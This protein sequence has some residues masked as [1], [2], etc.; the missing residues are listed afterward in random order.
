MFHAR[1]GRLSTT[2]E[3]TRRS[4]VA[5]TSR[6]NC[7]F[8]VHTLYQRRDVGATFCSCQTS[9]LICLI[10]ERVKFLSVCACLQSVHTVKRQQNSL[11]NISSSQCSTIEIPRTCSFLHTCLRDKCVAH[12][13]VNLCRSGE[14]ERWSE[15]STGRLKSVQRGC[16]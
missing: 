10:C 6:Q 16:D 15:A 9:C 4:P 11:Q 1:I 3:I 8:D 7:Y 12:S 5:S 13:L 14:S 2:F